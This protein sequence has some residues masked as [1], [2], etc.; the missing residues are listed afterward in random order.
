LNDGNYHHLVFTRTQATGTLTLYVDGAVVATGHASTQ[1]LTS[2]PGLRLGALQS[3]ANFFAGNL[4]DA[5]IY[6]TALPPATIT[7]HY[8]ARN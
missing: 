5:A 8:H 2:A 1:P 7:A 3:G 4:T 6:D